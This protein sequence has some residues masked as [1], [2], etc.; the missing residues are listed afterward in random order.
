MTWTFVLSSY[1]KKMATNRE[2]SF[3]CHSFDFRFGLK[4]R[5]SRENGLIWDQCSDSNMRFNN[6]VKK[7][8]KS[9]KSD[10]ALSQ[11]PASFE[12]TVSSIRFRCCALCFLLASTPHPCIYRLHEVVWSASLQ[13]H[14]CFILSIARHCWSKCW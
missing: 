5:C 1:I 11:I 8:R 12:V 10:S 14:Y 13:P 4:H 6:K 7:K 3:I 2:N 9:Q